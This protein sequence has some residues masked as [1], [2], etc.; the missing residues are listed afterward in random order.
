MKKTII[1]L[2]ALALILSCATLKTSKPDF[3]NLYDNLDHAENLYFWEQFHAG[4]IENVDSIIGK[5]E[6]QY[7]KDSTNLIA[8]A[9][10][11][12][13]HIWALSEW[14]RI[15]NVTA[16]ITD[17]A[18]LSY[19]H[20]GKA[21]QLNPNDKRILGFLADLT[22]AYGSISK[23]KKL[24]RQGYF[25]GLKSI[26]AWP[27]FNKFTIGV[28]F[29]SSSPTTNFFKKAL[30]WQWTTLED[31]YTAPIDRK[32][33]NIQAFLS[34]EN[35]QHNL[36]KDR[37]CYNSWI[38][39]HNIEGYFLHM[40]DMITKTG[41]AKTAVKIY[42]LAKSSPNYA[43]WAFK[44]VLETRIKNAELNTKVF[45]AKNQKGINN[46][47]I[48][49]S[50]NLCMSCHKMTAEDKALFKNYNWIDYFK[51][52]DIYALKGLK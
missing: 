36:G 28:T 40:G 20:F 23:S 48:N 24:Q 18:Y 6:R 5:L 31:C 10:L 44:D 30:N 49:N 11:G 45:L 37:A 25:K 4:N 26:R 33:P 9:H 21:Y 2:T 19:K 50:G 39:P 38:A 47:I 34:Q 22:M 52:S 35:A 32:N 43:T 1:A 3:D 42:E 16:K 27:E 15:P 41:D 51:S 7:K 13:A 14:Q 8:N 12:F 46:V 17:H 29:A